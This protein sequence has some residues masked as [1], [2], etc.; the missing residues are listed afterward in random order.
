MHNQFMQMMDLLMN[1]LTSV[2]KK[3]EDYDAHVM[4]KEMKAFISK[5]SINVLNLIGK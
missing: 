2:R 4:A 1:D 5:G 3:N